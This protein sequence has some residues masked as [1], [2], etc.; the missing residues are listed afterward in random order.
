MKQIY[1]SCMLLVLAAASVAAQNAMRRE[2]KIKVIV[3]GDTLRN[4]WVGGLHT[5]QFNAADIDGDG[6]K[7]LVVF[8]RAIL[9]SNPESNGF[10]VLTFRN[11]GTPGQVDYHYKP[12]WEALFPPLVFWMKMDDMN[13]DGIPDILSSNQSQNSFFNWYEGFRDNTGLLY[14]EYRDT[15]NTS[16]QFAPVGLQRADYPGVGDVDR[17]GDMDFINFNAD[18]NLFSFYKNNAI[19]TSGSCHDTIGHEIAEY[20]WGEMAIN[21]SGVQLNYLCPFK[22]GPTGGGSG[23]NRHN[24]GSVLIIDLDG[25]GD[26]DLIYGEVDKKNLFAIYNGGTTAHALIDSVD[27][28]YPSYDIPSSITYYPL[29]FGIDV[30]NNGKKDIIVAPSEPMISSSKNSVLFYENIS[31]NDSIKVRLKQNNFLEGE[32]IELGLGASPTLVDFNGDSLLDLV[33]G[34]YGYYRDSTIATAQLAL[35]I[36]IGTAEVPVFKLEDDDWLDYSQWYFN[37][38]MVVMAL[39]PAFGDIDGDG[40]LDLFVGDTSGYI[41]FFENTAGAG[42]VMAF[43]TPVRQYADIYVGKYSAPYVYDINGDSLPDLLIG[44]RQGVIKY[45]ENRGTSSAPVFDVIPANPVLGEIIVSTPFSLQGYS[46]PI[47]TALD[48]T[49]TLYLLSGNEEGRIYGYEFNPDNIYGGPFVQKFDYY[50]GIDAG[51]R[52][53][54]T[55]ADLT[56]DGKPEMIVGN[57]RGGLE[58]Y[59]LSDSI[60]NIIAVP[61]LQANIFNIIIAPN[62]TAGEVFISV[63]GIEP[64]VPLTYSVFGLLGNEVVRHIAEPTADTWQGSISIGRFPAG[65]YFV[66][67]GQAQNYQTIKLIKY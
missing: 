57:H 66:R 33:V 49:G 13:C 26:D 47:I 35:F 28:H 67:I 53:T 10:K 3:N 21:A 17:D 7:D 50:S 9:A 30:N 29:A 12:E 38:A 1:L 14:F 46:R 54:L 32:M 64:Y 34:N 20:C 8:N 40:D 22:D 18:F 37:D 15:L 42:N 58:F 23:D 2:D 44:N 25:D 6:I 11:H 5:P 36:N 51:E 63:S 61:N 16:N 65:I 39:S 60:A 62:P 41:T 43:T 31:P 4:P 52:T 55:V 48:T 19:E 45:F 56:N 27:S 24:G 59:T